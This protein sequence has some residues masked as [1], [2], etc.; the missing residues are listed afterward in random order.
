[1]EAEAEST[2]NPKHRSELR[3]AVWREGLVQALSSEVCSACNLRHP[4][5]TSDIAQ[6]SGYDRWI[7]VLQSGVEVCRHVFG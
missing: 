1:M 5:S 7:T 3:I 4:L 2:D 6:R